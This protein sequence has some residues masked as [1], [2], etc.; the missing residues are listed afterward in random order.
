MRNS[1]AR[2]ILTSLR[3]VY[4]YLTASVTSNISPTTLH[5]EAGIMNALHLCAFANLHGPT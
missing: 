1:A 4:C 2:V 3:H 5:Y